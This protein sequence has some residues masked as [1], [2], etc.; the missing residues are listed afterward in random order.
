MAKAATASG[1]L[2]HTGA[3]RYRV[4][5]NGNLLT[6]IHSLDE[7]SHTDAL[8]DVVMATAT[9]RMPTI[10]ANYID[11]YGQLEIRTEEIDEWFEISSI[12]IFVRPVA[13][14]YPQ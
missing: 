13:T 5:G 10:L 14:G 2:L 11:Q 8:P 4:I 1:D 7:A 6:D 3:V 9:N 12:V